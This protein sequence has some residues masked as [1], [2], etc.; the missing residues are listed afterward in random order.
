MNT[1]PKPDASSPNPDRSDHV[2]SEQIVRLALEACPNGV[3][4][5]DRLRNIVF[6]NAEIERVFGYARAELMGQ[7]IDD[8]LPPALRVMHR[9]HRAGLV[10]DAEAVRMGIGRYSYG[11]RKD[12]TEVPVEIGLNLLHAGDDI[13]TLSVIT[14]VTERKLADERLRLVIE[15]CPSGMIMS[16]PDGTIVL[17]NGEAERIFGYAR[18]ELF[19]KPIEVLVPESARG[20]HV[21]QR[22]Q[23]VEMKEARR[24]GIGR[25]LYGLRKDGTQIPIELG[26][27]PIRTA[28]GLMM[29]SA[30]TDIS[31]RKLAEERL[32][33][34]Q[35]HMVERAE[36][37][38]LEAEAATGRL[39]LVNM[40]LDRL[41]G[42]NAT[43]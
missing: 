18:E 5:T 41:L 43:S 30:I 7:S 19:G 24:M 4:I 21:K 3:V 6:V 20:G 42:R 27:N 36:R 15:A 11:L 13:M 16:E 22:E 17:I 8:L 40:E 35:T 34:L 26:F 38:K 29:L 25:D 14:D 39:A 1:S 37:E 33:Q 31:G 9:N 32:H 10:D 12:G 23:T 2:V 28:D